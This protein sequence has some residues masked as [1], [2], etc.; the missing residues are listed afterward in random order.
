MGKSGVQVFPGLPVPQPQLTRSRSQGVK[1][2]QSIKS[3]SAYTYV[4][5][6]Q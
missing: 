5:V 6:I 2:A 1:S 3:A 4:P